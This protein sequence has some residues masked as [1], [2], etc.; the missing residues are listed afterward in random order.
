MNRQKFFLV[1]IGLLLTSFAYSQEL[2]SSERK[3]LELSKRKFTW[4]IEKDYDSLNLMLDD[5]LMYVHSN[6]WIQSK[7]E[8]IDD[9]KSGKLIYKNITVKEATIRTYA[10]SSVVNGLGTFEGVTDG[11]A[12]TIELRYTEVYIKKG[13]KWMLASRHANRMP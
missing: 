7:K 2:T 10:K 3:I 9:L 6:G 4:L 1:C 12:F 11:N 5:R 8:V 13:S